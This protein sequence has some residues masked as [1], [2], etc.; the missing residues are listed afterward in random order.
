[1]TN[2]DLCIFDGCY[3]VVMFGA[4]SVD[5]YAQRNDLTETV[6]TIA[7]PRTKFPKKGVSQNKS[8]KSGV[9]FA[10]ENV[11]QLTTFHQRSTTL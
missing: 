3:F 2:V 6:P 9:F 11:R 10:S 1:M 7:I 8:G 5:L 4:R